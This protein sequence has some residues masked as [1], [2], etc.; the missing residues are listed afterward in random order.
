MLTYDCKDVF[1]A[2]YSYWSVYNL[3]AALFY[4]CGF[5]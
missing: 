1:I 3:W 5:K 2:L 4:W